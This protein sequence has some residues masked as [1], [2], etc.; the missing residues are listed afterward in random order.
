MS[1]T[2]WLRSAEIILF[3]LLNTSE[4]LA[5]MAGIAGMSNGVLIGRG[6]CTLVILPL[7]DWIELGIKGSIAQGV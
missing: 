2:S 1:S 6:K 5:D 4:Y 7:F 3:K